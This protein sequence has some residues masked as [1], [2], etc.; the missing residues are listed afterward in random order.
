MKFKVGQE[1]VGEKT[2]ISE[3]ILSVCL[4]HAH[5]AEF[6]TLGYYLVYFHS[7]CFCYGTSLL[8]GNAALIATS[9]IISATG[10]TI[11]FIPQYTVALYTNIDKN[12]YKQQ[13]QVNELRT[14]KLQYIIIQYSKTHL[15]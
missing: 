3:S 4:F 8:H 2:L 15:N 10:C 7:K 9:K 1:I 6:T 14:T 13:K 12:R 11:I 5:V